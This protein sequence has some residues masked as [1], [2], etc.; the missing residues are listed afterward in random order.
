MATTSAAGMLTPQTNGNIVLSET[1][2]GNMALRA[3]QQRKK[4]EADKELLQARANTPLSP[5]PRV[6]HTH[7]TG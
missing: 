4:A 1:Q 5:N 3:K 6:A 7:T 2:L